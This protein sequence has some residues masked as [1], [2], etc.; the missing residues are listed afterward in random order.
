[1]D[2]NTSN[3]LDQGGQRC[4]QEGKSEME[5]ILTKYQLTGESIDEPHAEWSRK[6]SEGLPVSLPEKIAQTR[7]RGTTSVDLDHANATLQKADM[8]EVPVSLQSRE[9]DGKSFGMLEMVQ[10]EYQGMYQ[11]TMK[12]FNLV[13]NQQETLNWLEEE[14][15]KVWLQQ[16]ELQQLK[17]GMQGQQLLDR[18]KESNTE[19]LQGAVCLGVNPDSALVTK[20]DKSQRKELAS[21][22]V[23]PSGE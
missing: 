7:T 23:K 16:T 3:Q 8:Q 22:R 2:L 12:L 18:M 13:L 14:F 6:E 10:E 1:M 17:Q 21:I 5:S 11:L 15:Q 9:G 19:L 4:N 20:G